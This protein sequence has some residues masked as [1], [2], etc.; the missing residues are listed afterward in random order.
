ME[1][2]DLLDHLGHLV[3]YETWQQ[4]VIKQTM[5]IWQKEREKM[6]NMG[7]VKYCKIMKADTNKNG[8]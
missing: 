3:Y 1:I 6:K 2:I 7:V 8:H 5:L 4:N